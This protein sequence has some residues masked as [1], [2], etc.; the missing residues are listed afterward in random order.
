MKSSWY[1]HVTDIAEVDIQR[2][3]DE[4]KDKNI[5]IITNSTGKIIV[6]FVREKF[7]SKFYVEDK[8]KFCGENLHLLWGEDHCLKLILEEN[9]SF[10][11]CSFNRSS[12]LN[13]YISLHGWRYKY[14]GLS[15]MTEK[16]VVEEFEL[17][18]KFSR[19]IAVTV[20]T[21]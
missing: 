10:A 7:L 6:V 21:L 8:I 11:V 12:S 20:L 4:S 17:A 14:A 19:K 18:K 3:L 9:G 2:I 16:I 13:G 5:V 1:F 15:V